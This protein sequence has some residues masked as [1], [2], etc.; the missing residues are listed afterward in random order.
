MPQIMATVMVVITSV[1]L[2]ISRP[3][4][5]FVATTDLMKLR[6][7]HRRATGITLQCSKEV[8]DVVCRS[9]CRNG[10]QKQTG[11]K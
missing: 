6:W 9:R 1:E 3:M 8:Y 2:S 5:S 4:I 10:H 7:R 11:G